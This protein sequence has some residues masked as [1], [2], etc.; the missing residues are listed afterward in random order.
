MRSE[1]TDNDILD[2]FSQMVRNKTENHFIPV[3]SSVWNDIE[4]RLMPS[5]KQSIVAWPW[6]AAGVAAVLVGIFFMLNPFVKNNT[7]DKPVAQ[8][9]TVTEEAVVSPDKRQIQTKEK[10]EEKLIDKERHTDRKKS[11]PEVQNKETYPASKSTNLIADYLKSKKLAE[12]ETVAEKAEQEKNPDIQPE[13]EQFVSEDKKEESEDVEER[14]PEENLPENM[15]EKKSENKKRLL[16]AQLGGGSANSGFNIGAAN[17]YSNAPLANFN[18]NLSSD[19]NFPDDKA[20]SY[21]SLK[22]SDFTEIRHLPP[23]SFSLMTGFPLNRTWSIE[24]GIMYTYMVSDLKR[25]SGDDYRGTLRLHYLGIPVSLRMNL[26][27]NARWSVYAMG[28]GSIEK[29]L[30]SVYTQEI[31]ST[32]GEIYTIKSRSSVD[33]VQLSTQAGVGVDYKLNERIRL[34]GEPRVI[35]YFNNKQPISAR[36]ENPFTFSLNAG[37]RVEFGKKDTP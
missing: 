19:F 25:T 18:G 5:K 2:D 3:E 8:E 29:G 33:G 30:L 32:S 14:K 34:F 16:I 20:E 17:H 24:T 10:N 27:E 37:I 35:Y 6:I 36:T 26:Y 21:G 1:H 31:K 22:P 7:T 4:V 28:G 13:N 15:A 23:V 9:M 12:K 11:V